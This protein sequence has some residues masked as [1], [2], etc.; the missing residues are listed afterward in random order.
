MA[1]YTFFSSAHGLLSRRDNIVGHKISR[2]LNK[3]KRIEIIS[4][5]FS[6][7][8]SIKLEINYRKKKGKNTNMETK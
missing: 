3:F 6:D 7:H 5:I 8:N 2:P 1:E 4:S